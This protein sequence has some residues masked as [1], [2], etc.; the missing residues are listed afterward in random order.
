MTG[1]V[2]HSNTLQI[3]DDVPHHQEILAALL[4]EY[5]DATIV[6]PSIINLYHND[7][8]RAYMG[9]VEENHPDAVWYLLPENTY[10][11][12]EEYCCNGARYYTSSSDYVSFPQIKVKSSL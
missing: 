6:T 3:V 1:A 5:P 7:A 11:A 10:G 9:K 8:L 4:L 12:P 2:V